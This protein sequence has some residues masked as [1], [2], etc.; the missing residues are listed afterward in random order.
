MQTNDRSRGVLPIGRRLALPL[1]QIGGH[2]R[3]EDEEGDTGALIAAAVFEERERIAAA[4]CETTIRA[5]FTV[6]LHLASVDFAVACPARTKLDLAIGAVDTAIRE[7]RLSIFAPP[8]FPALPKVSQGA[9]L[10]S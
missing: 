9:R 3:P 2:L 5:M 4:V 6:S 10:A 7:L 8:Q 1:G